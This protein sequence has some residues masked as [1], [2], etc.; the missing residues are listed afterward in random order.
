LVIGGD[1]NPDLLKLT[2]VWKRGSSHAVRSSTLV[3]DLLPQPATAK[4]V[5]RV[6]VIGAQYVERIAASVRLD[7]EVVR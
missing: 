5:S 7:L 1:A 6:L 2:N 3:V 4:G